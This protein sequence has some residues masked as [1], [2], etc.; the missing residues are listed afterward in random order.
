MKYVNRYE[1]VGFQDKGR[2]ILE[3]G[4]DNWGVERREGRVKRKGNFAGTRVVQN[5]GLFRHWP[6]RAPG[7]QRTSEV[8]S[9]Y[10]RTWALLP[11]FQKM[12]LSWF[13]Q[14]PAFALG[15]EGWCPSSWG[16]AHACCMPVWLTHSK[17]PG[18]RG[19]VS[20]PACQFFSCVITHHCCRIEC[21]CATPPWWECLKPCSPVFNLLKENVKNLYVIIGFW[22]A[23]VLL[24][25]S[26]KQLPVG[27]NPN[28]GYWNWG[29]L[30]V[31]AQT[32]PA[33]WPRLGH[34]V[35]LRV[36]TYKVGLVMSAP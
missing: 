27:S 32:P 30:W 26:K 3:Q 16:K 9:V 24:G 36:L 21:P 6:W 14:T 15:G 34:L 1:E 29:C 19:W 33:V 2:N 10:V 8:V 31:P 35:S 25:R 7:K 4:S 5:E 17:S 13:M 11:Q 23:F 28:S 12:R 20:G 18:H 22:S